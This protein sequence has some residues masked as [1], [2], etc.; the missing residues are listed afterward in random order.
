MAAALIATDALTVIVLAL[1]FV[2]I[3]LPAAD[4]YQEARVKNHARFELELIALDTF[5]RF[6]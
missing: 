2:I 5:N 1:K 6:Q 3:C 4:M